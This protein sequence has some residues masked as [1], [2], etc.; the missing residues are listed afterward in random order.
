MCII[1]SEHVYELRVATGGDGGL[2]KNNETK[3]RPPPLYTDTLL[4]RDC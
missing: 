4:L 3:T 2:E 1:G